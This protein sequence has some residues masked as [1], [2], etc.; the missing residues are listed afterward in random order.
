MKTMKLSAIGLLIAM[1]VLMINGCGSSGSGGTSA[2][3]TAQSGE[4]RPEDNGVK[5]STGVIDGMMDD[6][7]T[8][9]DRMMDGGESSTQK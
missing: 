1:G 9:I 8:E 4:S 6:A 2:A 3:P 7:E 5:E